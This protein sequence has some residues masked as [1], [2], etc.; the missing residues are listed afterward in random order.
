[1]NFKKTEIAMLLCVLSAFA[2]SAYFHAEMPESMA[3]HWNARGEADGY[4]SKFWGL[5]STPLILFAIML[6]FIVIP[7]IDPL[8][9]NYAKFRPYFDGL[10]LALAAFMLVVQVQLILW[11]TG[12]HIS[13][14]RILP[15]PLGLLFFYVGILCEHAKM[16][17]F[18]G[19]RT[20]WTLSNEKVWDKT[21]HLGGKLFKLAGAVAVLGVFFEKLAMFFVVAPLLL[22]AVYTVIYSYIAYQK[23]TK[24]LAA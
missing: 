18:V 4:T 7:R 3:S 9:A 17:W 5:F 15:I 12:T 24:S 6:L 14:N 19:I 16:N 13:P 1:M 23:E 11:N 8:K 21:H 2:L 20:P 10:F 22:V